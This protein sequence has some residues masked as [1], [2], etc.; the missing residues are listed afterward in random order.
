[1]S[2]AQFTTMEGRHP[3]QR[4]DLDRDRVRERW[5]AR[6]IQAVEPSDLGIGVAERSADRGSLELDDPVERRAALTEE[7]TEAARSRT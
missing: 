2:S 4:H 3:V 5:R 6:K 1:M 7:T